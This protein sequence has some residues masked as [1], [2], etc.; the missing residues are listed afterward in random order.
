VWSVDSSGTPKQ[1]TSRVSIEVTCNTQLGFQ[2]D[3]KLKCKKMDTLVGR[4]RLPKVSSIHKKASIT[5]HRRVASSKPISIRKKVQR[6]RSRPSIENSSLAEGESNSTSTTS[7]LACSAVLSK[8]K[9]DAES[10]RK[11]LT[12]LSFSDRK[13]RKA[14]LAANRRRQNQP[15]SV[16]MAV[17]ATAPSIKPTTKRARKKIVI[18][19]TLHE[20]AVD[21]QRRSKAANNA[22]QKKARNDKRDK[23]NVQTTQLCDRAHEKNRTTNPFSNASSKASSLADRKAADLKAADLK[24]ADLKAADR[25]AADRKAADLKAADRKAADR[26]AAAER[27]RKRLK[28][29]CKY[30]PSLKADKQ[31]VGEFTRN[32]SKP[33]KLFSSSAVGILGQIVNTH[34]QTTNR[35]KA[36]EK[37]NQRKEARQSFDNAAT[38]HNRLERSPPPQGDENNISEM[39]D[40]VAQRISPVRAESPVH[41]LSNIIFSPDHISNNRRAL[42]RKRS[43]ALLHSDLHLITRIRDGD[44]SFLSDGDSKSKSEAKFLLVPQRLPYLRPRKH[45][46]TAF[47][48]HEGN[49]V[50]K[51]AAEVSGGTAAG[52]FFGGAAK[53]SQELEELSRQH[54]QPASTVRDP[55]QMTQSSTNSRGRKSKR[56][57]LIS[58]QNQITDSKATDIVKCANTRRVRD[59][60]KKSSK[61]AKKNRSSKETPPVEKYSCPTFHP[62]SLHPEIVAMAAEIRISPLIWRRFTRSM[63]SKPSKKDIQ[64][65]S[66]S[67]V[68]TPLVSCRSI[69]CGSSSSTRVVDYEHLTTCN[70]KGSNGAAPRPETCMGTK[71]EASDGKSQARASHPTEEDRAESINVPADNITLCGQAEHMKSTNGKNKIIF[72]VHEAG[73][74]PKPCIK[75]GE[76]ETR[77]TRSK[78]LLKDPDPTMWSSTGPAKSEEKVVYDIQCAQAIHLF[79]NEPEGEMEN[80]AT[81]TSLSKICQVTAQPAQLSKQQLL[82]T[83]KGRISIKKRSTRRVSFGPNIKEARPVTTKKSGTFKISESVSN[84]KIPA[85]QGEEHAEVWTAKDTLSL[86]K[87]VTA[88]DPT[89]NLFW[90]NVA[91]ITT[92]SVAECQEKW[93]ALLKTPNKTPNSQRKGGSTPKAKS[94]VYAGDDDI[95]QSTPFRT[96]TDADDDEPEN[97][98]QIMLPEDVDTSPIRN[99][100]KKRRGTPNPQK[101]TDDCF[102]HIR[103]SPLMET[104]GFKRYIKGIAQEH[105]K[106]RQA[107]KEYESKHLNVGEQTTACSTKSSFHVGDLGM[108]GYLDPR[109][110]KVCVQGPSESDLEDHMG[111][112]LDADDES[113]AS[114]QE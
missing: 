87:A 81:G 68:K 80:S 74:S 100:G 4:S 96:A 30:Q 76:A 59:R 66:S 89:S 112:D 21:E 60:E 42:K 91:N 105:K 10:N 86:R 69:L 26:K 114:D 41:D 43:E 111:F 22:K 101:Q 14:V 77:L 8:V 58:D 49:S 55:P 62:A 33:S 51:L 57:K 11:A 16:L 82:V 23:E 61:K 18:S 25:K 37:L 107:Q 29:N 34:S 94:E 108:G 83:E 103:D 44:D 46:G 106:S 99:S 79:P 102:G 98:P 70:D 78:S 50:R 75:K 36:L 39:N 38:L 3:E 85:R 35:A 40:N 2:C 109:G 104:K 12:K 64:P 1:R 113:G 5:K 17:V 95:F 92:K 110:Y 71:E 97:W 63:S 48:D 31:A 32:R 28:P 73:R 53:S 13:S 93:F 67:P 88:T 45:I 6:M 24:A 72:D 20:A 65:C 47:D 90:E 7:V 15:A 54:R 56:I 84:S 27:Y 9:H 52:I 19:E